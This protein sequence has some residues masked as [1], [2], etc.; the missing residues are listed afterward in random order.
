M[1]VTCVSS[2]MRTSRSSSLGRARASCPHYGVHGPGHS[3]SGPSLRAAHPCCWV[4]GIIGIRKGRRGFGEGEGGGEERKRKGKSKRG[5]HAAALAH[6]CAM[7]GDIEGF[8]S[9]LQMVN[10]GIIGI[11]KRRGRS[12][13]LLGPSTCPLGVWGVYVQSPSCLE[14]DLFLVPFPAMA[15]SPMAQLPK[16]K[17]EKCDRSATRILPMWTSPA[18]CHSP[19]GGMGV[20]SG[21]HLRQ[22]MHTFTHVPAP[23]P[24]PPAC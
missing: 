3:T 16:P 6:G 24:R 5:E 1:Q 22:H 10:P 7:C 11:R 18:E 19:N 23:A 9:A 17:E 4:I 12:L 13:L 21:A 14:S 20:F 8:F 2:N 15:G